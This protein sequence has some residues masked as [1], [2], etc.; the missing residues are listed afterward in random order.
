MQQGKMNGLS[1]FKIILVSYIFWKKYDSSRLSFVLPYRQT[2]MKITLH[3][4]SQ[5]ASNIWEKNPL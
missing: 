3:F 4:A 5:A 1:I 2:S